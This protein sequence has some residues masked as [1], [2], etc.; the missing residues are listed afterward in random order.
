MKKDSETTTDESL[1]VS[2]NIVNDLPIEKANYQKAITFS[3]QNDNDDLEKN[4]YDEPPIKISNDDV[5]LHI[6]SL[7]KSDNS[8]NSGLNLEIEELP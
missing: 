5:Q 1:T 2:N 4:Y 8:D 3:E 6:E 7:D